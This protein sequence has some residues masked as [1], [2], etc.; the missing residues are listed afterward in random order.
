VVVG[1]LLSTLALT[2]MLRKRG[3]GFGLALLAFLYCGNPGRFLTF[4]FPSTGKP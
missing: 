2:I 4:T 3:R 1:A